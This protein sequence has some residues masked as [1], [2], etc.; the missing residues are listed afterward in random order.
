MTH[1]PPKDSS[2]KWLTDV[3]AWADN[4]T[5]AIVAH[6]GG[7]IERD[8]FKMWAPAHFSVTFPSAVHVCDEDILLAVRLVGRATT[9]VRRVRTLDG[10]HAEMMERLVVGGLRLL[11]GAVKGTNGQ[12]LPLMGDLCRHLD[13]LNKKTAA[14]KT[15][16]QN[17]PAWRGVHIRPSA[18]TLMDLLDFETLTQPASELALSLFKRSVSERPWQGG[19]LAETLR[20][21][22]R[23]AHHDLRSSWRSRM[24][25]DPELGGALCLSV[26]KYGQIWTREEVEMVGRW[27]TSPDG[28]YTILDLFPDETLAMA[29]KTNSRLKDLPV[30][31]DAAERFACRAVLHQVAGEA[32]IAKTPRLV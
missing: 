18:E 30:V 21:R 14:P 7:E 8:C 28:L 15:A 11:K 5:A 10:N 27:K 31:A 19:G 3:S 1:S 9:H 32:G 23:H 6:A 13:E 26:M 24:A 12:G 4:L 2:S 25:V 20:S 29:L 17:R 16:S 22:A